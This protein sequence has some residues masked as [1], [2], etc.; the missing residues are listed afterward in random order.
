MAKF[1]LFMCC[2]GNGTTVCN[3]AVLEHGD[4][5]TVAHISEHGVIKLY[6]PENYIP[7]DAMQKIK[8]LAA[9]DKEKFL[10][11]WNKKSTIDKYAYIMEIPT[12]EC[13]FSVFQTI[14]RNN[15]NLPLEERVKLM[16]DKF[17]ITHM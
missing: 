12:I 2:L 3:K 1:E 7:D 9:K 16:E 13:G 8:E 10:Q 17:F 6:V 11:K 15:R 4:Y 5:K 14:D